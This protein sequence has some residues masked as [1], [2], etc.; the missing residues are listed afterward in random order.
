MRILLG[1]ACVVV[2]TVLALC[3]IDLAVIFGRSLRVRRA[4]RWVVRIAHWGRK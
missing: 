2:G 3:A 1:M 4:V